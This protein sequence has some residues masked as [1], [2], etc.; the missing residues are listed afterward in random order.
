MGYLIPQM[1][2]QQQA[3]AIFYNK[4]IMNTIDFF[5]DDIHINP[6]LLRAVGDA[7]GNCRIGIKIGNTG[8]HTGAAYTRGK[9]RRITISDPK[10]LRDKPGKV[11]VLHEGVHGLVELFY[12]RA[13]ELQD[14]T[15]AYIAEMVYARMTAVSFNLE[16]SPI[17]KAAFEITEK[18]TMRTKKG[19]KLQSDKDCAELIEA[20]RREPA[21]R[22]LSDKALQ[23][24]SAGNRHGKA[25]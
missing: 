18:H 11:A 6:R 13:S 22:N 9:E 4:P 25:A 19:V 8:R 17:H 24:C 16:V 10:V 21:Y 20:I 7:I 23:Y 1:L 12:C 5:V 15:V 3:A 14:E 2:L